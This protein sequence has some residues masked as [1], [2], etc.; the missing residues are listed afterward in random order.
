MIE[1]L[2]PVSRPMKVEGGY[3]VELFEKRDLDAL[4]EIY[5]KAAATLLQHNR[6]LLPTAYLHLRRNPFTQ[7]PGDALYEMHIKD[8]HF[9][10][11]VTAQYFSRLVRLVNTK[12]HSRGVVVISRCEALNLSEGGLSSVAPQAVHVGLQ[13]EHV[14]KDWLA[15]IEPCLT[16]GHHLSDFAVPEHDLV[17]T[18]GDLMKFYDRETGQKEREENKD[19]AAKMLI[20]VAAK[21]GVRLEKAAT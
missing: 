1:D 17:S 19:E 7:E 9:R 4:G 6:D 3:P 21:L 18:F 13:T 14:R 11:A 5:Q 10:P 15:V 16:H 2:V 12:G 20:E 8:T